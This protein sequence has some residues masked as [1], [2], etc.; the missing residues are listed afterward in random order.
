MF[1]LA[2]SGEDWLAPS[3]MIR[4]ADENLYQAKRLGRNRVVSGLATD[5]SQKR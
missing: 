3:E 5:D 2:T 4:I 1:A